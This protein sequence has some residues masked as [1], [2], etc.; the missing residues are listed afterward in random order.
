VSV[1]LPPVRGEDR[2][3]THGNLVKN[4][5]PYAITVDH[6]IAALLQDL[7]ARGLFEDALDSG[8][9]EFGRTPF[10]HGSHGL[11]HNQFGFSVWLVGG[12]ARGGSVYGATNVFG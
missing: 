5:A 8:S 12:G 7:K 6:P 1:K 2:W 10:S 4:H 11:D 3:D 9:R